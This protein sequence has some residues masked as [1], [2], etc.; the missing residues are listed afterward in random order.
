MERLAEFVSITG[1]DVEIGTKY[2]RRFDTFEE[3]LEMY[4][5]TRDHSPIRK[6]D[7][8]FNEVL[9]QSPQKCKKERVT[10]IRVDRTQSFKSG[11]SRRFRPCSLAQPGTFDAV[12][13]KAKF[14]DKKLLVSLYNECNSACTRQ[15]ADIWS[16]VRF[17]KLSSKLLFFQLRVDSDEGVDFVKMYHQAETPVLPHSALI[18]PRTGVLVA[19]WA[20]LDM[21]DELELKLGSS[22]GD[23]VETYNPRKRELIIDQ[24]E[25]EQIA[26]ALAAS[27][28]Q[29]KR[30]LDKKF[31]KYFFKYLF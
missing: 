15:N 23:Q 19:K 16:S 21:L 29:A 11:G 6:P 10:K 5:E 25:D 30:R 31:E 18:D 28:K 4:L 26:I 27:L 7:A 14:L 3:A 2:M 9:I 17:N 13:K 12:K 8:P 1:C 22:G 20:R 24:D